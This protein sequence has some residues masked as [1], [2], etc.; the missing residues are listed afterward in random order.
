V[1]GPATTQN[2][3]SAGGLDSENRI[4]AFWTRQ[5]PFAQL[6]ALRRASSVFCQ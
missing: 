3:R 1:T 5:R 6:D 4:I 2:H